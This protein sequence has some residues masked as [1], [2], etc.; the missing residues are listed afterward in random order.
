[1]TNTLAPRV[2]TLGDQ[3]AVAA[4]A[5]E[6]GT[7]A[8]VSSVTYASPAAVDPDGPVQ[9]SIG[10]QV[11]AANSAL[12]GGAELTIAPTE[13]P[14]NTYRVFKL[15]PLLSAVIDAFCVNVY[16]AGFQLEAVLPL[17]DPDSKLRVRQVLA[18]QHAVAARD[19][20]HAVDIS[21]EAVDA[22]MK[23]LRT[24][25][26]NERQ[27]VQAWFARAVAGDSYLHLCTVT[28]QDLEIQGDA[29]WEVLRDTSGAPA[30]LVWAPAWSIRAKPLDDLPIAIAVPVPASELSWTMEEQLRRFRSYVQTD[31]NGTII[32]RYKEFGDPRCLSRRTGK[33]YP[34]LDA[35]KAVPDEWVYDADHQPYPPLAAAELL[36]FRLPNP[37]S[38]AYG[39]PG[40]TGVYPVLEGTRD[41]SEENQHLVTDQ[42]VPQMFILIAGGAGIAQEQLNRLQ[43]QI[44]QN[45][46]DGK[47]AIYFIQARS[48]KNDMGRQS[49]TPTVTVERTKSE[50]YQDA[51]GLKYHEHA[52]QQVEHAYRLPAAAL[53]RHAGMAEGT[54]QAGYRFAEAQVYDPRRDLFDDRI[55]TTLLPALG[56]QLLR[57]RTR[58][59]VPKEPNEL[60]QIIKLLMEAG[61]LTPDEGRALAGDIFG[62]PF[63][64]LQGIWSK[65]PTKLLL[66]MLQTKNQLVGAAL[67]GSETEAD[68]IERLQAALL[69]QLN[70]ATGEG[71]LQPPKVQGNADGRRAEEDPSG[72]ERE[73]KGG[74]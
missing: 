33:Y 64:D 5:G 61:V 58:S 54:I 48:A 10:D 66:A 36:H 65:L 60:A 63:H 21:D 43:E 67:L 27:F 50:Q 45:T 55:N 72:V 31:L 25:A 19:Y 38:A 46:K 12:T 34:T 29:Y 69:A 71:A 70:G 56:V 2:P 52:E 59:R 13:P 17:D 49:P 11:F 3:A 42:R 53:G 8:S 1:M 57:Y 44:E 23:R 62:K 18:Y 73:G 37:L 40:F 6:D 16:S 41:L 9:G 35:M 22:E 51:L 15:S 24:R 39:K 28:G 14:E 20:E 32:A 26:S 4:G 74:A 7:A 47:K 68:I 30:K